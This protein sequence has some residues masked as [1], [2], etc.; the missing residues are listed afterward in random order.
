MYI[1]SELPDAKAKERYGSYFFIKL[2]RQKS[3][4]MFGLE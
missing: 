3:F 4:Q 2:T 1:E